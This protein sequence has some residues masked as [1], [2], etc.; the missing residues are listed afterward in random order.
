M[1]HFNVPQDTWGVLDVQQELKM[2]KAMQYEHAER[3]LQHSERIGRLERRQDD[4]RIRSLWSTPSPFPP[5]LSSGPFSQPEPIHPEPSEDFSGF[6]E[7]QQH[8]LLAGLQLDEVDVPRRGASRANSVRFDDSAIQN[9]WIDDSQPQNDYFGHRNNNSLGGYPMTE[10]SSSHKSDGRQ[11]SMRSYGDNSSFFDGEIGAG[12]PPPL[13]N[14]DILDCNAQRPSVPPAGPA[15]AIIRCWIDAASFDSVFY[16]I[17]CTGSVKSLIDMSFISRLGMQEQMSKGKNGEYRIELPVFLPDAVIQQSARGTSQAQ[18]PRLTVQFTVV[19]NQQPKCKNNEVEIF[20]GSDVLSA[21]MG[22][23]LFSQNKVLLH[24]DDGRKMFVPFSRP[25]THECFSDVCTIHIG[26]HLSGRCLEQVSQDSVNHTQ[27]ESTL[28]CQ[29]S[30]GSASQE[31]DD[32]GIELGRN[33]TSLSSPKPVRGRQASVIS[34][35]TTMASPDYSADQHQA[36]DSESQGRDSTMHDGDFGSEKKALKG[37]KQSF[38]LATRDPPQRSDNDSSSQQEG[39]KDRRNS[40]AATKADGEGNAT[41][42]SN[43]AKTGGSVGGSGKDAGVW[44]SWRKSGPTQ[45]QEAGNTPGAGK[46]SWSSSKGMKVLRTSKSSSLSD[47]RA[48]HQLESGSNSETPSPNVK[49]APPGFNRAVSSSHPDSGEKKVL[50]R[51]QQRA[52]SGEVNPSIAKNHQPGHTKTKSTNVV[53]G[54][55]AFHWMTPKASTPTD[56]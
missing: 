18:L 31:T 5:L 1:E 53:G 10:R 14:P 52:S 8:D 30:G 17:V 15:P 12:F 32:S 44:E 47:A 48:S 43:T 50:V 19:P 34:S 35:V 16:A 23:V 26:D 41:Q 7:Q 45:K 13:Q 51:S 29:H 38:S 25:D 9:H 28:R 56:E 54:A 11:S 42:R 20:L 4:S 37:R 2:L 39:I 3:L 22:D 55:S 24:V 40:H 6:S 46:S 36:P 49:T 27:Q 21:H 33:Q